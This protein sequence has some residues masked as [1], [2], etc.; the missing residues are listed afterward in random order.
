MFNID[1]HQLI[2]ML[3]PLM[4]A[5][6]IHEAAHGYIALRMGDAT[7]LMM[8]RVTLNP[9]RHMD[10]IGSFILPLLLYVTGMPFLFGY[11]KPVPV[12]SRNFRNFKKGTIMVAAAGVTANLITALISGLLFQILNT[13][14]G[15]FLTSSLGHAVFVD[16]SNLLAYSVII[17][18]VLMIFNLIPI[19][20]L[21]GS[22]I[23]A[24]VLPIHLRMAYARI[25][26]FGMI[27]LIIILYTGI[28]GTIYRL[29]V[30][31]IAGLLLGG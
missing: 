29:L 2:I 12:N 30:R 25:E 19:P 18:L 22:R 8:G 28:F 27:I 24:V 11:A 16:L 31:P 9:I 15:F 21:D 5:V 26:R 20:P 4:F 23:M 14:A 3:I 17:N 7:A 13:G 1:F 10:P 6:T